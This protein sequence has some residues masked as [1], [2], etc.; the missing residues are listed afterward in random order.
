V[1]VIRYRVRDPN[2]PKGWKEKTEAVPEARN[3]KQALIALDKRMQEINSANNSPRPLCVTFESFAST[4]WPSF[5]ANKNYKPSTVYNYK[6]LLNNFILPGLGKKRLDEIRPEDITRFFN[7][8]RAKEISGKYL[9]NVYCLVKMMF[10]LAV[11]YDI[12]NVSPVRRK[13][14][15]PHW[16]RKEKPALSAEEIR[17][18][19]ENIPDKYRA[20]FITVAITGLRLGELLALRWLNLSFD[21]KQLTI[22]HSLWRKQLVSPKTKASTKSIRIPAALVALLEDHR[23]RSRWTS[24]GDFVFCKEDGSPLDPDT[25]RRRVLYPAISKA[26]IK[27]VS[28]SHGFH[29]FRHSAGSIVHA[30]TRDLKMAQELL[31]HSR[32]ATTA[33]V[34]IHVDEAVAEEAT[35]VLARAIIPNCGLIAAQGSD[36]IQ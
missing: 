10:D 31:R 29:L 19:I 2:S 4:L 22:T 6:S 26:E 27:R 11:E 28:R 15:R 33:D 9:L 8:L 3:E 5:V 34:Y 32:I 14:H 35:E 16:E 30:Q 17:K 36:K 23:A 12:I 13:L 21:Q 7:H 20:L 24:L 25:M 18:I 1:W